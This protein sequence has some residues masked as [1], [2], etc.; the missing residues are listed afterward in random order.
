MTLEELISALFIGGGGGGFLALFGGGGGG[1]FLPFVALLNVEKLAVLLATLPWD[2]AG[3]TDRSPYD[4]S[5]LPLFSVESSDGS[6]K[7]SG[8]FVF[9]L[10]AGRSCARIPAGSLGPEAFR[11]LTGVDS[12]YMEVGPWNVVE[13]PKFGL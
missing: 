4:R 1:P 11:P 3:L 8:P 7:T 12:R 10:L 2:V 9:I 5:G 6:P 13:R